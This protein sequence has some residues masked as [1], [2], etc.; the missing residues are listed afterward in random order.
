MSLQRVRDELFI[1][2][3]GSPARELILD[4][5]AGAGIE[6]NTLFASTN[7][8]HVRAM[9]HQGLGYAVIAQVPG[10]TPPHWSD[11]VTHP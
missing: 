3:A 10:F 2:L 7:Y 11:T 4:L 1:P 8:D 6:P 5:F 9:V